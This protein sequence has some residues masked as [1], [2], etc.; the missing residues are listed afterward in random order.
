MNNLKRI[1][2]KKYPKLQRYIRY[3]F[4]LIPEE[5]KPEDYTLGA[6][7]LSKKI[8]M[9][10]G[11]WSLFLP[12]PERQSGR[13]L[14]TMACTCFSAL[15]IIEALFKRKF[16]LEKN[17]SDRFLA[18]MSGVSYNGNTQSRVLD[19]I[20]K[21]GLVDEA[22]WPSNMDEFNWNEYYKIVPKEI[23]DKALTFVN[24]YE[25]GYEAI[26]PTL[27]AMREALKYSP[28]Y[29]AGFAWSESGGIYYSYGNPNHAFVIYNIEQAQAFKKAFDSYSPWQK[30]LAPQ[31]Q[32]YYPKLI[33][34][35][36]RGEA[37]NKTEIQNLIKRGFVYIMRVL[38]QGEIYRLD[39]DKLT[40]ISP[41]EW[42]T[43]NVQMAAEQKKLV[44]ISEEVF[45]KL[46][47]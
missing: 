15:N 17:F 5:L 11:D 29:V 3:N 7:P 23:Q 19:T 47:I 6:S 38:A 27:P 34:L 33:V 28:L 24:D 44:G 41:E 36:K 32:V 12:A 20:R 22:D 21:D 8:L 37:Y 14:E 45:N 42:N 1:I 46:L 31:Y 16:S 35:N 40:Y 30:R 9:P 43:L 18:K 13:S 39:G 26:P 4:G 10:D 2:I 25:V